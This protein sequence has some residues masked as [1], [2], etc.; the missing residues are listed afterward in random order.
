MRSIIT[1]LSNY[2]PVG[3][4]ARGAAWINTAVKEVFRVNINYSRATQRAYEKVW[5]MRSR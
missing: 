1:E 4:I 3:L 5:N 2:R